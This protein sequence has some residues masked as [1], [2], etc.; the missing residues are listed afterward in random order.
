MSRPVPQPKVWPDAAE[1]TASKR[2]WAA[3]ML[4][5][6]LEVCRSILLGRPVFA[7]QLDAEGPSACPTRRASAR[8]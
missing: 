3:I 8:P 5:D 6:D 7:R 1:E 2:L 4:T